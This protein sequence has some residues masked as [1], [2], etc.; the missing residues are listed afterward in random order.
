ML[1]YLDRRQPDA[2]FDDTPPN[3]RNDSLSP[4]T[5]LSCEINLSA[6]VSEGE[7]DAFNYSKICSSID[8]VRAPLRRLGGCGFNCFSGSDSRDDEP[9]MPVL[10]HRGYILPLWDE[11]G[12]PRL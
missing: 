12:V 10:R 4:S 11:Q 8:C 5:A 2:Q 9:Q 7:H 6:G 1:E 3:A